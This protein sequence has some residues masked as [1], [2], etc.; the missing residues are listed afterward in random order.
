MFALFFVLW[1][2]LNGRVTL[3]IV[4]FGLAISAAIC[5]FAVRIV[6]YRP[7]TSVR[8]LRNIPLLFLY[9]L[10]LIVEIFKAGAAVMSVA[11]RRSARPDPVIVEFR[12]GLET[13]LKNVLLANS[14]TL[15]PGTYTLFQDGD[16]F[17]VHCLRRE[18]AEGMQDSSFIKL[19]RKIK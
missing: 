19:L 7:E 3:E 10:N 4:L 9:I 1:I 16:H 13:N 17:V 14:I 2:I 5:V 8:I 11:L 6:G 12:S 15:T 18:Y